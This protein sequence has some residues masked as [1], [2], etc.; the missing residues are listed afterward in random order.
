VRVVFQHA[1][2]QVARDGLDNVIRLSGFEPAGDDG[3]S[4]VVEPPAKSGGVTQCAPGGV[5]L[6]A[7]LARI[8]R[9]VLA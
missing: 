1:P 2:R 9:V 8:E 5:P 3:V 6:A 4:E 7:R